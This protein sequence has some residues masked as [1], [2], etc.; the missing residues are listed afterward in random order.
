MGIEAT[1]VP[2]S[3]VLDGLNV[4]RRMLGRTWIDSN[5]CERGIRYG[6]IGASGMKTSRTGPRRPFTI[7]LLTE[8]TRC[9]HLLAVS[10]IPPRRKLISVAGRAS[11]HRVEVSGQHDLLCMGAR[12]RP[13]HWR[14]CIF[15]TASAWRPTS[16]S[17]DGPQRAERLAERERR[18][19]NLASRASLCAILG[20]RTKGTSRLVNCYRKGE[21][22]GAHSQIGT[23]D[24]VP[25]RPNARPVAVSGALAGAG[26]FPF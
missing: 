20:R 24:N 25:F 14:W 5:R 2:A 7:F 26:T 12:R 3:N 1:I 18:P 16:C 17:V 6:N 13:S 9:E 8:L 10:T 21:P 4:V 11:G 15:A 23:C 22:A 19:Q